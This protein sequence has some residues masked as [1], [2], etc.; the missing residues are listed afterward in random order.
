MTVDMDT[1]RASGAVSRRGTKRTTADEP[2][3][4]PPSAAL[5]QI[6][7]S[8]L[9]AQAVSVAAELGV[10]DLLSEGPRSVGELAQ[11][12]GTHAPSLQRLLRFLASLGI[13]A[14]DERGHVGLTPLAAP[15]CADAPGSLQALSRLMGGP[16][17]RHA[18]GGLVHSVRT[19]EAAIPQAYGMSLWAYLAQHPEQAALFNDHFTTQSERQIPA[20]LEAYDFAGIGTLVDVGGGHGALL[21]AILSA[22]P[23]QHG[24]LYDQPDVVAGAAPVLAAA[25]LA[26]RITARGGDVFASVPEGGDAYVIKNVLH[27]W[28]DEQ[29]S[30]ILSNVQRV[31]RPGGRLLLIE[32]VIHPGNAPQ[33][34][35]LLDLMM[36]ALF[37]S[38][39]R[40]VAEWEALLNASGFHVAQILPTRAELSVIEAI[41]A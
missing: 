34:G 36:L 10:A 21:S 26:D 32:H 35:T 9:A 14:Q 15:L 5:A 31:L 16:V 29:A 27:N 19:G 41:R 2:G 24:I 8:G 17:V 11:Q 18:M 33:Y 40:T 23:G 37:G 39:E 12:T 28:D 13:F 20:I 4:G 22:H 7:T 38:R 30:V 6:M 25:G 3:H 1:D